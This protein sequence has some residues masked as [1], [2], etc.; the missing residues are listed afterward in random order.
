M[1]WRINHRK[2]IV[3]FLEFLN[4]KDRMFI[5]KGGTSLMLHYG[6]TRF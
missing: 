3:S 1:D 5:L 6:L 2:I 4:E